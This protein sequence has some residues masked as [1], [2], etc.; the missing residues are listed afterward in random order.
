MHSVSNRRHDRAGL[1]LIE[2]L[3]VIAIIAV[4]IGLL[5]PAVQKARAAASRVQSMNNLKQIGLAMHHYADANK[6]YLP[7]VNGFN[8]A[9]GT[10]D[11]AILVGL[12]PYIDQGNVF[13]E[14]R[15]KFGPDTVDG[16]YIIS[17]YLSPA[18]PTAIRPLGLASYAANAQ[19]FAPR[20]K[21]RN[22]FSDGTSNTVAFA[23][24][25]A[26]CGGSSFSWGYPDASRDEK[27][28]K[29]GLRRATFADEELNDVIPVTRAFVSRGSIPGLTFQVQPSPTECNPR[30]A[31]TPHSG[32]MLAAIADGS[33]R[34]LHAAMAETVYWGAVT[35]RGGEVLNDW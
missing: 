19:A 27:T 3:V 10:L 6:G 14:Y 13:A 31:Q 26:K 7:S 18:D 32:G 16:R 1:T 2:L 22:G 12:M 11:N 33:V 24:H 20:T 28:G 15:S 23:E 29:I 35:P 17:A 4:L 21:L 30:L 25:Y 8:Y 34:T 9:H 5:L